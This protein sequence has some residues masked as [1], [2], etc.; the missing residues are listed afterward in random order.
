MASYFVTAPKFRLKRSVRTQKTNRAGKLP[1]LPCPDVFLRQTAAAIVSLPR[2]KAKY[3]LTGHIKFDF[4]V[5]ACYRKELKHVW[6]VLPIC[7]IAAD[8]FEEYFLCLPEFS[9]R[10]TSPIGIDKH[11]FCNY[12]SLNIAAQTGA[13]CLNS[14]QQRSGL[15]NN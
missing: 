10:R 7:H 15:L 14:W 1:G 3:L 9:R 13:N 2:I 4:S 11:V 12:S 6:G 8:S 5:N